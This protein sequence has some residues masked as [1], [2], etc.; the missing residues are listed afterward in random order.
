MARWLKAIAELVRGPEF[1]SQHPHGSLPPVTPVPVD[2][3]PFSNSHDELG[4]HPYIH[5]ARNICM[6]KSKNIFS[7]NTFSKGT[8]VK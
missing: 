5:A 4:I 2:P 1:S 3:K 8:G 6:L 7:R